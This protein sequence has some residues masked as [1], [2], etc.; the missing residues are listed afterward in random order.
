MDLYYIFLTVA[1]IFSIF[2]ILLS[3]LATGISSWC[4]VAGITKME[5]AMDV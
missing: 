1:L 2:V 3:F 4:I 5:L